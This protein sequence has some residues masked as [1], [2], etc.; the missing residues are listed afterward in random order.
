MQYRDH[1][2]MSFPAGFAFSG[3]KTK[4]AITG[5]RMKDMGYEVGTP[6]LFIPTLGEKG[7]FIEM[8]VKRKGRLSEAQ[9]NVME[10]LEK[11]GYICAVCHDVEEFV[12]TI[13][14]YMKA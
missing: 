3:D 2:I 6:D 4:R 11:M 7:I 14:T 10:K 5:K 13:K 9:K 12:K 8:K 1:I